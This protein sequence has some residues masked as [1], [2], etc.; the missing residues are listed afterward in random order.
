MSPP[1][2]AEPEAVKIVECEAVKVVEFEAVKLT[3]ALKITSAGGPSKEAVPT[4][5][6]A[7][8]CIGY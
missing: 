1:S 6:F 8:K 7:K 4:T 3:V 5:E 2:G